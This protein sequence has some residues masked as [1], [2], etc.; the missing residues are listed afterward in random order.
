MVPRLFEYTPSPLPKTLVV[1][2][3]A[4]N[5]SGGGGLAGTEAEQPD[6]LVGEG[7]G[8]GGEGLEGAEQPKLGAPEW[9]RVERE[10]HELA[11]EGGPGF[12][13]PD[14]ERLIV[15]VHA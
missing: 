10:G 13:P 14:D 3:G 5:T 7:R 4:V 12:D 2:S 9:R 6:G 8:D 11:H 15:L 1:V